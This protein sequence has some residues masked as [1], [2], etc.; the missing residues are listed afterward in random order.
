MT[1]WNPNGDYDHAEPVMPDG[2][3]DVSALEVAVDRLRRARAANAPATFGAAEQDALLAALADAARLREA[4]Y[5]AELSDGCLDMI[6]EMLVNL[7]GEEA[8]SATPPMMYPEAIMSAC[9]KAAQIAAATGNPKPSLPLT[10]EA[11]ALRAEDAARAAE[12][13]K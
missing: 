5:H 4:L 9:A 8:M 7:L 13:E 6:H 1:E 3:H 2:E 11:V 10:D 12:S